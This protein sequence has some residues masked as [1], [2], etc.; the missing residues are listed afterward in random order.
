MTGSDEVGNA[1]VGLSRRRAL[2]AAGVCFAMA[3][4]KALAAMGSQAAKDASRAMSRKPTFTKDCEADGM[5]EIAGI[6]QGKGSGRAKI[7]R[8]AGE[9]APAYFMIYDLPPGASEGVHVHFLDNRNKEGSFDEYYYVISGQGQMTIDG[10]IVAV[11]KGDHVHT[12]L[13]VSH[14]VENT[15]A[16]E[17]LRIFLTFIQ[18]GDEIPWMGPRSQAAG[19]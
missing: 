19:S 16:T 6:H 1:P 13:E 10:E 15:H 7:F 14:G 8:F 2:A 11:T 18:R 5:V 4:Q 12:P 17:P 3:S 9:S